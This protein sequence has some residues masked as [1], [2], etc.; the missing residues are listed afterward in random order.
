MYYEILCKS[1]DSKESVSKDA[2][3]NDNGSTEYSELDISMNRQEIITVFHSMIQPNA[4][5]K[6]P[7]Y[8][9]YKEPFQRFAY[10]SLQISRIMKHQVEMTL[11][12][13]IEEDRN[14]IIKKQPT[15]VD[16]FHG[17]NVQKI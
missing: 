1:T 17:F 15:I 13:Y 3:D 12:E 11:P 2:T 16:R 4:S 5:T 8:H 9:V 7:L 6:Y 14:L 10:E